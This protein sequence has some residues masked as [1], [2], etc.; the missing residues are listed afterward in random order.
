MSDELKDR[1]ARTRE[2]IERAKDGDED[3]IQALAQ[4]NS[5]FALRVAGYGQVALAETMLRLIDEDADLFGE[6]E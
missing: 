2:M 3:A 5:G 6:S 4:I 1:M